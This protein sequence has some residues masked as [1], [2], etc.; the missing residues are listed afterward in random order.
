MDYN[1]GLALLSETFGKNSIALQYAGRQKNYAGKVAYEIIKAAGL[2]DIRTW[3]D[4]IREVQNMQSIEL[5]EPRFPDFKK[6]D[7][8]ELI[9]PKQDHGINGFDPAIEALESTETKSIAEY[10]P[11]IRRVIHEYA[12]L[13]QERS[14]LH[15]AMT[16]MPES[17]AEAVCNKRA[18]IFGLIKSL[19]DRLETLYAVNSAYVSDGTLPD[20]TELYPVSP[21]PEITQ[22][23]IEAGASTLPADEESLKKQKKNLQSGNSKD[24][25][26]LDYQGGTHDEKKPMPNGPK[27]IK[28][29][30]RMQERSKRI[31]E[32]DLLLLR[33]SADHVG[34]E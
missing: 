22:P 5:V 14:K 20:E 30:M 10:P 8:P 28:I 4:Y 13:F 33:P 21:A 12:E 27:R 24:Q 2:G 7:I 15:A 9:I 3:K 17:N 23:T 25:A 16:E 29:E 1:Q 18:D 34:K 19:S 31:E 11:V 26:I 32:I 6:G